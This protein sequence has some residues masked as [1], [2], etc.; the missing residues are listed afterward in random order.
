MSK[1]LVIGI[2]AL[3]SKMLSK[4]ENDLPNFRR[5]RE[6]NPNVKMDG[7]LP[8][9]S[10]TSWASIYTGLNPAQHGI[11]LFIDPLDKVTTI[12][13][14][15]IDNSEIQGKTF[16]D[17]A[18]S[19]GKKVCV[20]TPL[21]GYPIWPVN[22]VMIGRSLLEQD[23][24]VFPQELYNS[25]P[26]SQLLEPKGFPG[27]G[28]RLEQ[29]IKSLGKHV[30]D[31]AEF[32]LRIL[33]EQ[34]WNLFFTYSGAMDAI[35]GFFWMY[36]DESDPS[37]PGDNPCQNIIKDFYVLHDEIIGRFLDAVDSD[38]ITIVVSDHGMGL[39]PTKLLNI[40]EIL[41]R[42]SLLVL[43]DTS[44]LSVNAPAHLTIRLIEKSK[45]WAL[46]KI[47]KYN[48]GNLAQLLLRIFPQGR[49]IYTSPLSIDWQ[50][51]SAYLSDLS[52]IK[53][54]SYGGIRINQERVGDRELEEMKSLIIEELSRIRDPDTDEKLV[55]RVCRREELY[56]GKHISLYPEI[57]Y[58][59]KEDY[60]GGWTAS[61]S[62][63]GKSYSHSL[64]SGGHMRHSPTFLM[65][66]QG[67]KP[68][69]ENIALMDV[70][71]TVLELLG[72]EGDFGFAGRSLFVE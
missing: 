64:V 58:E 36:Y 14:E 27:K 17:L 2:D 53:A 13:S 59:L 4:F 71:P 7:V 56:S 43:K 38:T 70:A 24:Q 12:V 23:F 51:T 52:G 34:D 50:K 46:R 69:R 66:K 60:G 35:Q 30:L 3:D 9:D 1:V 72:V 45:G 61:S 55:K 15:E 47:H 39:R 21:L 6:V 44:L 10:Q 25:Y 31:H 37:Y 16:W 28:K 8:P 33:K 63:F 42:N 19:C 5:L 11:L 20:I 48:L 57:V 54:Y 65:S 29:Y 18:G 40:N 67:K 26:L 32:S 49:R 68:M 62:L 22:G 41:R